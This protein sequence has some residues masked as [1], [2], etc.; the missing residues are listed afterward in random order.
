VAV[1]FGISTPEH[2]AEVVQHCEAVVV[3][4]AIV[5]RIAEN[6][7]RADFLERIANFVKPLAAA[8]KRV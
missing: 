4:S 7:D 5:K 6:A 8:T 2:V 1:G 3:E